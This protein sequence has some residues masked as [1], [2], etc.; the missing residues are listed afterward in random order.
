M[1]KSNDLTRRGFFGAS[2]GGLVGLES[3]NLSSVE[4][5]HRPIPLPAPMSVSI[6]A[7]PALVLDAEIMEV[8]LKRMAEHTRAAQVGFRPYVTTHKCPVIARRQ[9]ELGAAGIAVAKISEAEVMVAVV[10]RNND[11]FD[12][13]ELILHCRAEMSD[14][15]VPRYIRVVDEL[16][17]NHAQRVEKYR[18]REEGLTPDAW[19]R[20]KEEALG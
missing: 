6:M 11:S 18:L 12:C 13:S 15:A 14:H 1:A 9:L 16:P 4:Q 7:T 5:R 8:N 10:P 20:L 3:A 2:L 19:D 17:K